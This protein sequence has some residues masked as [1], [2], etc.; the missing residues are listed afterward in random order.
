MYI[1]LY[2]LIKS[3]GNN[4]KTKNGWLFFGVVVVCLLCKIFPHFNADIRWTD[5]L[6]RGGGGDEANFSFEKK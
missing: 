6:K 2:F 4:N 1:M 3:Q 5:R